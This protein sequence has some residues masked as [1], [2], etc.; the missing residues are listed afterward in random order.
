MLK[1]YVDRIFFLSESVIAV[2][3]RN[4]E[5]R[6]L[7][8]QKFEPSAYNPEAFFSDFFMKEPPSPEDLMT[9]SQYNPTS[10]SNL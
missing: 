2:V 7:Y 6:L 8:T 9:M 4:L 1:H 10:T 3:T 5:I